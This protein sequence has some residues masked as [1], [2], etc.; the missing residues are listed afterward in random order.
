MGR[1]TG[2]GRT[3]R[4]TS[5]SWQQQQQQVLYQAVAYQAVAAAGS[6]SGHSSSRYC[7]KP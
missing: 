2:G 4:P 6:V 7:I 1:Y 3:G 5:T